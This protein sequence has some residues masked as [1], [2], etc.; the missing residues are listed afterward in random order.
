MVC[1]TP[2]KDIHCSFLRCGHNKWVTVWVSHNGLK[3]EL[4]AEETA[5]CYEQL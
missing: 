3:I 1:I 4:K 2:G 5:L